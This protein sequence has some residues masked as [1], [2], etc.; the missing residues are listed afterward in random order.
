MKTT[1]N[2]KEHIRLTSAEIANL[3]GAYMANSMSVCILKFFYECAEDKEIKEVTRSALKISEHVMSKVTEIFNKDNFPIP[4]GFTEKDLNL[5][6]P[7]LYSDTFIINYLHQTTKSGYSMYGIALP[8]MARSDV[9]KFISDCIVS[10]TDLYNKIAEISLAKG[11]FIRPPYVT[12]PETVEFVESKGFLSGLLNR[13]RPLNTLEITHLFSNTQSNAIGAALLL[14][15]SQVT[16]SEKIRNY[17][18]RGREI[19]NKHVEIFSST[20]RKENLPAP[21]TWDQDVSDSK[22]SPFSEKLMLFHV[23]GLNALGV[24]NYGAALSGSQR[25]DLHAQYIRLITEIGVY[26]DDGAKLMIENQWLE[27]TPLTLDREKLTTV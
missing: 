14:G 8:L 27:Q 13:E 10:L 4:L 16:K 11:I 6:A 7:K 22:L 1:E 15:F 25:H 21:M 18:I 19:A 26:G 5:D 20:L 9:R 2:G 17:F 12:Y 24:Y 23:T 3:W